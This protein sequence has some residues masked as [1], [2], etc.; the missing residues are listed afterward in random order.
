[1]L[2]HLMEGKLDLTPV[3]IRALGS[4]A[5]EW[6]ARYYESL[7]D[8]RVM[9]EATAREIRELVDE[10][11]PQSGT[12]PDR[13]LE[14][15]ERV[16]VPLSRHNGHPRMFGYVASPGT[17]ASAIADLLASTLNANVT[18]W[19]SAPAATAIEHV[20]VNWIKEILG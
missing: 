13:L 20:A 16:I 8:R 14:T 18:A 6:M 9:P 7:P 2:T 4:A 17:A 5:V 12:G 19:R 3:E 11:L 15:F 1:M 10:A